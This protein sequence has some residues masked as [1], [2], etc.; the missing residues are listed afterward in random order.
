VLGRPKE[1]REQLD[2]NK[3]TKYP[4]FQMLARALDLFKRYHGY[5]ETNSCYLTTGSCPVQ[6][7]VWTKG[8]REKRWGTEKH[9]EIQNPAQYRENCITYLNSLLLGPAQSDRRHSSFEGTIDDW[10]RFNV[11]GKN[12]VQLLARLAIWCLPHRTI[13]PS[14]PRHSPGLS[15]RL[16]RCFCVIPRSDPPPKKAP[17]RRTNPTNAGTHRLWVGS[18]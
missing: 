18:V 8:G 13:S 17:S 1:A 3:T 16:Q 11:H 15:L 10:A 2:C 12:S 4:P 7:G 14:T 5:D 6:I 9:P